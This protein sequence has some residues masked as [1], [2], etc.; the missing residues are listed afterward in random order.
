MSPRQSELVIEQAGQFAVAQPLARQAEQ[1]TGRRVALDDVALAILDDQALGHGLDDR[2]QPSLTVLPRRLRLVQGRA[3]LQHPHGG[4]GV[5]AAATTETEST[6]SS[7]TALP[8]PTLINFSV[9]TELSAV[10]MK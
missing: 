7:A 4:V 9:V 1:R 2:A 10:K 5:G 8:C 6:I 3:V